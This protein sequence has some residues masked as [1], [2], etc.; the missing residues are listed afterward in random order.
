MWI[1]LIWSEVHLQFFQLLFFYYLSKVIPL[2]SPEATIIPNLL[3]RLVLI[4]ILITS[5]IAPQAYKAIE[6]ISNHPLPPFHDML[7]ITHSG[8][9]H[10]H[11][12]Q[13]FCLQVI[14]I[15]HYI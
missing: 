1:Y 12:D 13:T 3:I 14:Y 8:P 6:A 9:C 11:L 4:I 10:H 5:P 7:I 2:P 15:Y